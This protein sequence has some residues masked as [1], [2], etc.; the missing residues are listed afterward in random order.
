[1]R[2]TRTRQPNSGLVSNH[3]SVSRRS[4]TS[5]TTVTAG[6]LIRA[7]RA[8]AA[9]RSSVETTVVC[10]VVVPARVI[11]TGVSGDAAGGDQL[12]GDLADDLHGR[13]QDERAVSPWR[14]Q[15]TFSRQVTTVSSRWSL[16]VSGIPAY[17]GTDA[18]RG[19]ARHDLEAEPGLGAGQRLLGAGGVEE[20]VAGHQ[21]DHAQAALG[22]LDHDLGPGGVGQRLAVLAEAAVD[23][24]GPGLVGSTVAAHRRG[25]ALRARGTR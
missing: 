9:I 21:P 18:K 7:A 25:P 17:A 10:S 1:M 12:L 5:P 11:S 3:D 4:T 14:L 20:R 16:V 6:G 2:G 8:S 13:E 15:S 24:L 19:H 22:L 23:E